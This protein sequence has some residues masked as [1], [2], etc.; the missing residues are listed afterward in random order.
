[1]FARQTAGPRMTH[2]GRP[3]TPSLIGN[4]IRQA[5]ELVT[6]EV[7]LVRLEAT[8]KLTLA[9]VSVASVI[10]AAIFIIVALIFL[11]QG[12]VEV[13]VHAGFAP[14][15]AS[16]MVG[17]GIGVLALVAIFI[18]SRN[19]R[20]A[21]LKPSRAIGQAKVVADIIKGRSS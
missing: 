19:L 14:F 12:L 16:F 18:A 5:T 3:S 6:T 9:I 8:E 21:S 13:L 7:A 20:A 1:M 17:G 10:V 2:D 15:E 4:A 11:L